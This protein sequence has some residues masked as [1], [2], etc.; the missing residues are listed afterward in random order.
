MAAP[1]NENIKEI[2]LDAAQK[3]LS[4]KRFADISL[5]AVALK[6]GV[7]KGT[8]YYYKTKGEI[9]FDLTD[10]HLKQQWEDFILWTEN[11]E[12][13]TS[14]K[15]LIKYVIER[16][17][18]N[19]FFRM[20]LYNEAQAGDEVTRQKIVNRYSEFHTLISGKIAQ[21]TSQPASYITWLLFVISDGIIIQTAISNKNFNRDKFINETADYIV[22][23]LKGADN[24][25]P[26]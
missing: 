24:L 9:F 6:A 4:E 23:R 26:N 21:R 13:D 7:S 12:K 11:R 14:L 2:I 17:V 18:E 15:R 16:N 20:Q 25:P 22:Q 1:R 5:A 19:A 3:L 8:L 10:R